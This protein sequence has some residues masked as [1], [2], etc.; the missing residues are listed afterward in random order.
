[1]VL[2]PWKGRIWF[3]RPVWDVGMAKALVRVQEPSGEASP[4]ERD[5]EAS[6]LLEQEPER[7][8][9]RAPWALGLL[10]LAS[11]LRVVQPEVVSRKAVVSRKGA[12]R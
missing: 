4:L 12:S 7:E 10:E 3:V 9:E 8:R 2:G 11:P 1:M 6:L 5:A